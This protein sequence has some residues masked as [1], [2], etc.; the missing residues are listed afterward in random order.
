MIVENTARVKPARDQGPYFFPETQLHNPMQQ[1]D[2]N[3]EMHLVHE[4]A[5]P[6]I[7]NIFK[8]KAQCKT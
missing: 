6:L 2:L 8:K 3:P 1:L 4:L 5:S 7:H